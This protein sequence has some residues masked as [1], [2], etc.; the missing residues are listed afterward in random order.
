MYWYHNLSFRYKIPLRAAIFLFFTSILFTIAFIF[1][2][3]DKLNEDIQINNQRLS[4]MLVANLAPLIL[5]DDPWRAYELINSIVN[6]EDSDIQSIIVLDTQQRVFISSDA[7]RYPMLSSPERLLSSDENLI[8]NFPIRLDDSDIGSLIIQYNHDL[9]AQRYFAVTERSLMVALLIFLLLFP[10]SIYWGKRMAQPL[11]AL[12]SCLNR[13]GE[14]DNQEL[15]CQLYQS[16]DEIGQVTVALRN[17]F[18]QLQ[19]KHKIEQQLA[20]SERLAAIGRLSAGMAHE[21]NNPLGGMLN[22]IDTYKIHGLQDERTLKTLSMLE[23]GLKQIQDIVSALLV[24]VK[25][26]HSH[27]NDQDINDINTLLKTQLNTKNLHILWQTELTP[28]KDIP[29]ASTIMRQILFNLLLNAIQASKANHAI[30]CELLSQEQTV[31]VRVCN[32]GDVIDQSA[33]AQ[34]FEPFNSSHEHGH[35]LGLWITYQIVRQ[36]AGTI[37]VSSN[38]EQTCFSI[39]LPVHS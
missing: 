24:E 11:L 28:D 12:A 26:G 34:L 21:I 20:T 31:F 2:A 17:M 22:A 13:I 32:T 33:M 10:I 6:Y 36:L 16:N 4:T 15:N 30:L 8:F 27:F 9:F 14:H 18:N 35:G 38:A 5:H 25:T 7:K 19:H 39:M 29:I 3:H 37:D 1:L 23:R